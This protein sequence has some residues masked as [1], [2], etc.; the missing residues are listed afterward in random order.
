MERD[1][2]RGRTA[3]VLAVVLAAALPA[4]PGGSP[5]RE[6]GADGP[7]RDRG[8]DGRA[9]LRRDRGGDR[10]AERGWDLPADLL[11]ID[12]VPAPATVLYAVAADVNSFGLRTVSTS[13]NGSPT[14]V[15]G[16]N[17]YIDFEALSLAGQQEVLPVSPDRPQVMRDQPEGFQGIRIPGGGALYY[18][19]RKLLATSGLLLITADGG[20]EALLEVPGL[21]SETLANRVALAK[22]GKVGA[23]IQSP[24]KVHL[25]R[26]DGAKLPGGKPALEIAGASLGL[27]QVRPRSLTIAGQWLYC[28]GADANGKDRL[29]RA[30][31][32][33][34]SP[35]A[36]VTLPQS[37]G[38]DPI[39]IADQLAVSADGARLAVAAG[40]GG[41]ARDL[42]AVDAAGGS[43]VKLTAAPQPIAERGDDFGSLSGQ[44]AVSP[45][46][47]L[48]AFVAASGTHELFVA[49]SD[50]SV[51]PVQVT[52]GTRFAAEAAIVYNLHFPDDNNLLFMAGVSGSELDLYRWDQSAKTATNVTGFG[53]KQVPFDGKG[54][55]MPQAGWV[56]ENGKYLYWIAYHYATEIADLLRVDLTSFT[57]GNATTNVQ[58]GSQPG[59]IG[60]CAGG[61][62]YFAARPSPQI[63]S[64][65]VW[66]LDQ[67]AAGSAAKLTLM[68]PYP[69]AYWFVYNLT[70]AA[71][72]SQMVWSAGGAYNLRDLWLLP[73]SGGGA[74]KLTP[75][76]TY[77]STSLRVAPD[78]LSVVYGSGGS[79]DV[80]TLKVVPAWGGAPVTLDPTAGTVQIFAVY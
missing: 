2:D 59:A 49:R 42:Y 16:W 62:L 30:P 68:N 72:C 50:G 46:G 23:L 56:S 6:A 52:D 57:A 19:H 17:G 20:L 32:D 74:R 31:L 48:V 8:P 39:S 3:A 37:G 7:D 15:A 35:L 64:S 58:V 47:A 1:R 5:R 76:P 79:P 27:T 60:A 33:G 70:A 29:L 80:M 40:A 55:F 38:Q 24:A 21:Y 66:G 14:P 44:L 34:S 45:T 22:S 43:A 77:A 4:C 28:V 11:G 13:G 65:E 71:S 25:F 18:F 36:V 54:R 73:T 67:N 61:K 69:T 78:S 41:G 51:A 12:A 63:P 26:T 9:D 75:A 10:R 53:S